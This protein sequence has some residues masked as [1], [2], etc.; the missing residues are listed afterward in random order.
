MTLLMDFMR[1]VSITLE[2]HSDEK[3][4][5]IMEVSGKIIEVNDG[6]MDGCC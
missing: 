3:I 4:S 2:N 6:R 5:I 1:L